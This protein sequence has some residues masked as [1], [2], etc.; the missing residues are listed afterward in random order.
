V[1]SKG[2][3]ALISTLFSSPKIVE[4]R[5]SPFEIVSFMGI[6]KYLL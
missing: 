4:M 6:R 2:V 3:I 5:K 1:I